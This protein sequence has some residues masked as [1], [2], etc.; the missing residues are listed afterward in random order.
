[1]F[2]F[3]RPKYP[4]WLS[5]SIIFVLYASE[6]DDIIRSKNKKEREGITLF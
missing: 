4:Y 5:I 1:M 3:P 2:L 6:Y